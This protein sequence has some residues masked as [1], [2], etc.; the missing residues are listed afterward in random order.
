MS[1]KSF[2]P[3]PF[4][5]VYI[6]LSST[7][8]E[9]AHEINLP[10]ALYDS[11]HRSFLIYLDNDKFIPPALDEDRDYTNGLA[12][13]Y[14]AKNLAR[15]PLHQLNRLILSRSWALFNPSRNR[16]ELRDLAAG[17]SLG[18]LAYTPRDIAE[19]RVLFDDRPYASVHYLEF[20]TRLLDPSKNHVH[21][22]GISYG[23]LAS[24]IAEFAQR[25]IHT[26]G[27]I[28][29]L[30]EG[31]QNQI[32]HPWE[33]TLLL[34]Y[35]R[36]RIWES[37]R[38]NTTRLFSDVKES[39]SL[40]LGYRVLASYALTGRIGL[41]LGERRQGSLALFL[42]L[43]PYAIAYDA[44]LQGQFRPS[45]HTLESSQIRNFRVEGA[46]GLSFSWQFP[47]NVLM[48][49]YGFYVQSPEAVYPNHERFHYWGRLWL[50][51]RF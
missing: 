9:V 26:I 15:N 18:S 35:Q 40:D 42:R 22:F 31:W 7:A 46:G 20:R 36:D 4:F 17:L 21:S 23:I 33:P 24:P 48:T 16:H 27:N 1:K 10:T 3:L 11:S 51:W 41:Q 45:V 14:N 12:F 6:F 43:R 39:I 8:Q 25:V 29:P 2:L 28:R 13:S 37:N 49:G 50:G 38:Q 5:I 32:S 34:N 44:T 30:P 47:E 19:R